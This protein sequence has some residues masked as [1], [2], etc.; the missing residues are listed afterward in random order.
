MNKQTVQYIGIAGGALI[1]W[2]LS[3]KFNKWGTAGMVGAI[4]VGCVAGYYTS[5]MIYGYLVSKQPVS[6]TK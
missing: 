4:A 2:G 1:G 6:E 5:G 3:K